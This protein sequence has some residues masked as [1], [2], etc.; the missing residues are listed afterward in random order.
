MSNCQQCNGCALRPGGRAN[1]EILN[2]LTAAFS[3][4][5]GVPFFCHDKLGWTEEREADG[6]PGGERRMKN[7]LSN[8]MTAPK[9]IHDCPELGR[10]VSDATATGIPAE[11]FASDRA[12]VGRNPVCQGWREVVAQLKEAGW[13]DP[14]YAAHRRS[15]GQRGLLVIDA[16]KQEKAGS[17]ERKELLREMAFAT[18]KLVDEMKAAGPQVRT[19]IK[20]LLRIEA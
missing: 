16:V 8:L 7:H 5:G 2:R 11:I 19:A 9:L 13:F 6:Y 14:S 18:K 12:Y 20:D 15:I 17:P 1:R 4:I 10:A 3:A